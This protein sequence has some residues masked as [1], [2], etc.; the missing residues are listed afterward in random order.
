MITS[1]SEHWLR[2]LQTNFDQAKSY[3][4]EEKGMGY[5]YL[6]AFLWW[7][8]LSREECLQASQRLIARK[9]AAMMVILENASQFKLAKS[10]ANFSLVK[11]A[12]DPT[13][14]FCVAVFYYNL[15][16]HLLHINELQVT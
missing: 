7:A 8:Y 13:A 10:T 6:L 11:S 2:L 14:K 3:K 16:W 15:C 4:K 12:H 9:G 1:I 5:F